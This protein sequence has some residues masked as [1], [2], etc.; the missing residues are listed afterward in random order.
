MQILFHAKKKF[1]SSW[2]NSVMHLIIVWNNKL[3]YIEL[4]DVFYVASDQVDK[5]FTLLKKQQQ[6]VSHEFI[7][8]L[9]KMKN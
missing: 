8:H 2:M 7:F 4:C 3:R 5:M 6:N 1:L 9:L